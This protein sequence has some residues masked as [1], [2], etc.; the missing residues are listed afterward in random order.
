VIID[1]KIQV[2]FNSIAVIKRALPFIFHTY[3]G[4]FL[5][6][7]LLLLI[8]AMALYLLLG[9]QASDTLIEQ[10]LHR[11]QV[12]ARAGAKSVET[13]FDLFGKSLP[14]LAS[15]VEIENSENVQESLES[16]VE[17]WKDTPLS[18]VI[19]VDSEG[20]VK[21]NATEGGGMSVGTIVS[22]RAYYTWAKTAKKGDIFVSEPV[23][24]RIGSSSGKFIVVVATPVVG[25]NSEFAGLLAAAIVV[26]ELREYVNPLKIS[27]KTRIY[28]VNKD[29]VIIT[30]PVEKLTGVNYLDYIKESGIPG[31]L[32]VVEILKES[33]E[34]NQEGKMDLVLPNESKNGILTRYLIARAPINIHG[35]HWVLAVATPVDD[36]LEY[37]A[38]LYFRNL[39]IV[40]IAFLAFL[41]I[42]ARI[43]KVKGFEEGYDKGREKIE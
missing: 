5:L 23:I 39:G 7:G 22:D 1:I 8:L 14:G 24:S 27:D 25:G 38:P 12:A 26:E 34:S 3:N 30:S 42:V 19:F 10:M 9:K 41:L 37:L 33:I 29:G 4:I 43:A 2:H 13:F 31:S 16:Y 6:F 17:R 36:A 40:A 18:G 35:V 28:I 20:I 21:F 11:E 32:K 15:R